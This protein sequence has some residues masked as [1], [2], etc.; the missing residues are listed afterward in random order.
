MSADACGAM[1]VFAK[2]ELATQ[3]SAVRTDSLPLAADKT[4]S[5]ALLTYMTVATTTYCL[6]GLHLPE[7]AD[8]ER[9]ETPKIGCDWKRPR[10]DA[11]L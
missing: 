11:N 7:V 1:A 8:Q 9:T 6:V 3:L 10:C 4:T 2:P 5:G